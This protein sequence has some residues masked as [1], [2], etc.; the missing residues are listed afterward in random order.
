LTATAHPC[1]AASLA[2]AAPM[3]RLPPVIK[4]RGDGDDW[5]TSA[6]KFCRVAEIVGWQPVAGDLVYRKK[7]TR[8]RKQ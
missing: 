5:L 3:P 4:T 8:L 6:P 7:I 1:A 2:Q